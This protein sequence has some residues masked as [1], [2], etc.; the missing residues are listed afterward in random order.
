MWPETLGH[1]LRKSFFSEEKKQKTFIP[2]AHG[3]MPAKSRIYPLAQ[4]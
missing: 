4:K 3:S 1:T 2:G